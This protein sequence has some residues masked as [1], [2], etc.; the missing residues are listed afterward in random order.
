MKLETILKSLVGAIIIDTE[1]RIVY[2]GEDLLDEIGVT[3][4]DAQGRLLKDILPTSTM[5]DV[6]KTGDKKVGEM[7]FVEGYTAVSNSYPLYENGELIGAIEV[8]VFSN[9]EEVESF[10][11][12]VAVLPEIDK[13]ALSR[14]AKNRSKYARYSMD[15]IK[16]S[17]NSN[18]KLKEE[19]AYASK[20]NST[21]LITGETGCG[22]EL[23]AHAVHK[24]GQRSL[25]NFVRLNCAAIPSELFESEMF[26]Y[27][28]GSF[29]GASKEGK[30]GKVEVANNGTLFLDEIDSMPLFMQA[31]LLRFL[32]E[33]EITRVGGT[34]IIPVNTRVIAATNHDL[35]KLIA[36]NK[37]RK[38]LYYRL[39]VLEIKVPPL[40]ERKEDIPEIVQG[41]VD[42]LNVEL[43]RSAYKITSIDESIYPVLMMHDWPG[44][45]RELSN[46]VER[47]M[48]RSF[49]HELKLE[50]F[51]D[52]ILDVGSEEHKAEMTIDI[53]RHTIQSVKQ[54]A[55]KALIRYH[56]YKAQGNV[57]KVAG[58]IGISVQMLYRKLKQYDIKL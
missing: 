27:E 47:A 12:E 42:K 46:I 58:Q 45:I 2:M 20:S 29:T 41:I 7:Y 19:I 56:L 37:L 36:E 54:E 4:E 32:Q 55:E 3:A 51:E 39:N 30:L 23:V 5:Q 24:A 26:G 10:M 16:G 35:K 21:L 6:L 13:T 57:A 43:D 11:H 49:S 15:D 28:K 33:R 25:F 22:K 9:A 38:D 17:G 34:E 50:H 18:T 52:F 14:F 8:D 53:S 44:N 1:G 31:K 40:R 48:S